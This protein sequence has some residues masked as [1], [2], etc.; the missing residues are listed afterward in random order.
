MQTCPGQ[1]KPYMYKMQMSQLQP[2]FMTKAKA[3]K[4]AS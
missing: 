3:W 4:T 2:E 1:N